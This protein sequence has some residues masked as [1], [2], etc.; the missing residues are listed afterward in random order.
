MGV[1]TVKTGHLDLAGGKLGFYAGHLLM[2]GFHR[3]DDICY[4]VH[5]VQTHAAKLPLCR[6][7]CKDLNIV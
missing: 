7:S 5:L 4:G 6:H 3:L 1:V 2:H